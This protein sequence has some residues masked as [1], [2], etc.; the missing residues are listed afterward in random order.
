MAYVNPDTLQEV[1]N[2]LDDFDESTLIGLFKSQIIQDDSYVTIPVDHFEPLYVSYEKAMKIET[3]EEDDIAQIKE[4]FQNICLS[5]IQFIQAKFGFE[6]DTEWLETRYGDLPAITLALYRF[7]VIDIFYVIL[8]VLN[9]YIAKNS[10]DL[11][12]AFSDIPFKRDVS[13]ITNL[14]ILRPEYATIVS[15]LFDVTDYAFTLIDNDTLFDY[16]NQSYDP[17]TI[18]HGC[19]EQGIVTGD[20]ART[21]ADIYKGNL[22]LRS[23][24]AIELAYRIK[25]HGYLPE[26]SIIISS[27][28]LAMRSAANAMDEDSATE[29]CVDIDAD[30][31]TK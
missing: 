28:N 11:Y 4:K 19:V 18:L 7:F 16:I 27:E 29:A 5:I 10:N 1:A 13:T 20:F 8:G 31:D 12:K 15:S 9:N 24:V 6:L 17:A 2:I 30:V 21:I 25:E 3:A 23:K 22:E 26:N 14:K